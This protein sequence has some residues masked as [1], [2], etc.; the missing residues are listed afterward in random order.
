MAHYGAMGVTDDALLSALYGIDGTLFGATRRSDDALVDDDD[1]VVEKQ[2]EEEEEDDEG[3]DGDDDDDPKPYTWSIPS[4][5]SYFDS[6][7]TPDEYY[8]SPH[9]AHATV[10]MTLVHTLAMME[11]GTLI[12][13]STETGKSNGRSLT[14]GLLPLPE[15]CYLEPRAY[16]IYVHGPRPPRKVNNN[17]RPHRA[18]PPVTTEPT[19]DSSDKKDIGCNDRTQGEKEEGIPFARDDQVFML[20]L[21]CSLDAALLQTHIRLSDPLPPAAVFETAMVHAQ[22]M[23]SELAPAPAPHPPPGPHAQVAPNPPPP[24]PPGPHAQVVPIPPP[25]PPPRARR[26]TIVRVPYHKQKRYAPTQ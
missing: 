25:P 12:D 6:W 26:K 20:F 3:E 24:P 1:E 2:E 4:P 23:L 16:P 15:R 19:A 7:L 8:A 9:P 14:E 10:L 18:R 11:Y 13:F 21:P 5:D 22:T 17:R